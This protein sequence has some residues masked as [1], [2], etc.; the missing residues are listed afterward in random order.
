MSEAA[1]LHVAGFMDI[2]VDQQTMGLESTLPAEILQD[3]QS[4]PYVIDPLP[5]TELRDYS[6]NLAE[7]KLG[8]Y[9]NPLCA[10]DCD[11]LPL[12]HVGVT[13]QVQ[14]SNNTRAEWNGELQVSGQLRILE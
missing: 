6:S 9:Q 13:G 1:A 2:Q 7:P 11:T 3:V 10:P 12:L 5:V 14:F 4:M 8:W